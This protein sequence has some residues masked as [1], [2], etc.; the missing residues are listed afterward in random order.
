MAPYLDPESDPDLILSPEE[1]ARC[2]PGLDLVEPTDKRSTCFI[3]GY[4]QR[5]VSSG[6][7]LET[8]RGIRRFAPSEIARIM[9]LPEQFRFP[10]G[11]PMEARYK[12]LGNGLNIGVARWVMSHLL[13]DAEHGAKAAQCPSS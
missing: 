10:Q 5:F 4:G 9:G 7:F 8:P 2:G 13:R 3:G 12:L 11:L 1:V 6:S